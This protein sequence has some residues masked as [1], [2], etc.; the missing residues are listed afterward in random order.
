MVDFERLECA[1]AFELSGHGPVLAAFDGTGHTN[2]RITELQDVLFL[3]DVLDKGQSISVVQGRF[4]PLEGVLDPFAVQFVKS[5]RQR[6]PEF[7]AKYNGTFP[8]DELPGPV[9]ILGNLFSRNFGH[10]TEEM[11]KVAV[12]EASGWDGAYVIPQLPGFARDFLT[13]LGIPESRVLTVTRPTRFRRVTYTTA[14][15]H[16]NILDYPDALSALRS[17]TEDRLGPEPSPFGP[18]LWL[19]RAVGLNNTGI[20]KN[21][22]QVQSCIEPYGFQIVDPATLSVPDQLRAIRGATVLAGPHGAQ[23]VHVQFLP[24]R[25]TVIECFSPMYVNASV[26]QICRALKHRYHQV[27]SRCSVVFPY[28]Y[29]RDCEVDCEHLALVLETL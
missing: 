4:V 3:P 17:R 5:S 12:L 29:G 7:A 28:Q 10:W 24:R 8:V 20:V 13:F 27:V 15:N 14:I 23:F 1:S 2:I 26:I 25:S 11:M 22:A 19:D 16:D 21:K 6:I 9:C 18:K